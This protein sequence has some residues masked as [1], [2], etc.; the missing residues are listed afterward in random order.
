V[1]PRDDTGTPLTTA[2]IPRAQ[3]AGRRVARLAL[4]AMRDTGTDF[5]TNLAVSYRTAPIFAQVENKA[6][7]LLFRAGIFNRELYGWD[8]AR[9]PE[10]GNFPWVRSRVTYLQV[11][12]VATITAP[13]EL[14]P[15]LWIGYDTQWSWGQPVLTETVN[16]PDLSRAPAAPYLKQLMLDN[17][18]VQYA[19]VSGLSEDFLGYIVAKFNFVV[20]LQGAYIAEAEGDH[21]EETNSIGPGAEQ[22]LQGAMMQLARWRP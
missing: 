3:A 19:F 14:H 12:P 16:A 5:S 13:G 7:H 6:Y 4:Q 9:A 11:G 21:Y 17:A 10:P 15:E 22:F 2:G 1:H 8:T 18:G 20:A